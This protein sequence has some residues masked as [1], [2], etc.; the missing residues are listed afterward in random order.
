MVLELENEILAFCME[1]GGGG[2]GRSWWE[3]KYY[4]LFC[5]PKPLGD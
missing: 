2:G 4:Q 1:L 3:G 5:D